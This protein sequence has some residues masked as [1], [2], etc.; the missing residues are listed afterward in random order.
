[1]DLTIEAFT[2]LVNGCL[3]TPDDLAYIFLN[4]DGV[5][6]QPQPRQVR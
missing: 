2:G 4:S 5:S 6:V 3:S 1:M